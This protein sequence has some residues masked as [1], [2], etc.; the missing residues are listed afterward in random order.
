MIRKLRAGDIPLPTIMVCDSHDEADQCKAR[1]V[2]YVIRPEGMSDEDIIRKAMLLTLR[3]IFPHINWLSTFGVK[4][5]GARKVTVH[6]CHRTTSPSSGGGEGGNS[7]QIG[8]GYRWTNDDGSKPVEREMP[9]EDYV[10]DMSYSVNMDILMELGLLPTFMDDITE[11]IHKNLEKIAW[12]DGYNRKLGTCVGSFSP[13]SSA[14]NL[15]ILDTSASIPHSLAHTMISLIDTMRHNANADLIITSF[16]SR[17][18]RSDEPLPSHSELSRMIGGG[19]E[20]REFFDIL[21]SQV[22]GNHYGNVIVFGDFDAPSDNRMFDYDRP[23]LWT[24]HDRAIKNNQVD[25]KKMSGTRID[26]IMAYHVSAKSM[27]GYGLWAKA[28]APNAE[29]V[30]DNTWCESLC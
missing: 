18:W 8:D 7:V 28:L 11:A 24:D 15:I 22:A 2:P 20:R 25:A 6:E 1:G 23:Y 17:F 9:I 14:R 13:A 21:E 3:S 16:R 19:N 10:G 26:R 12:R 5:A 30:Y 29:I 4:F 27:P